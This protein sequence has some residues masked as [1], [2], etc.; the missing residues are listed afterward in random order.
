MIYTIQSIFYTINLYYN[1]DIMSRHIV[2]SALPY[3]NGKLHI[4]HVAGAYLPAD[5]YTRYLRLKE[6]DV[7]Y[8]C[9]T[10]EHGAP[11]SIKAEKEGVAPQVIVDRYHKSIKESF[12]GLNIE[13]DNF[14]GT[15]REPHHKLAQKFFTDLMENGFITSKVTQQFYDEKENRFL[16]DRYVEGVCPHC[17]ADGARGDQCDACGKLI[18]SITLQNPISKVS[19]TT[20][21]V[22]DTEQWYLDLPKFT[23]QL[24]EW[25]STK[26]YW[27]ENVVNF[28]MSW[29][30]EGLI[31]RAITRDINWGVKVPLTEALGK[32]LYVW[33]DAPIGYISSTIE[34]AKNQGKEELWKDY[35]CNQ[36][37]KL[38]HFIGKDNI[39]F[40]T[41][42]WPAFIMG[43]KDNYVLPHDVPANEYL[44]LEGQKI[45]TSRNWA[46][47]VDEFLQA[48]D[49][50]YLRYVLAV[51]APEK[52]DNDFLWKDFQNKINT[53]L[54]NVL[55][56]LGNRVFSFTKKHFAGEVTKPETLTKLSLETLE[57]T[58]KLITEID[59]NYSTYQVRKAVKNIM[60]IARLSNRY[61]DEREP[62]K[63]VKTDKDSVAETLY[64]C[65]EMLRKIS[66]VMSPIIPT[67]MGKLRS[68]MGLTNK[69]TWAEL[70]ESPFP[71]TLVDVKQI[72]FK[73]EDKQIAAQ[74]KLLQENAKQNKE[75]EAIEEVEVK[76][77][78]EFDD[79]MKMDLRIAEI[80]SAEKVKKTNKLLHVKVKIGTEERE[81]VAG[82][83]KAYKPEE[84]VGKKVVMLLNLKPRKIRG[85]LSS[86]MI[87]AASDGDK[88]SVLE[89][90]AAIRSG[91]TV[92]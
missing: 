27:K 42:M 51:N 9:G 32:V 47:W 17:S 44:N 35:W 11:I 86:G 91:S 12:D 49:G 76:P 28:I 72:F 89:P 6:E 75:E 3:A 61:F 33:F 52:Q 84:L 70:D 13:F 18:D 40:H 64:V 10:D 92:S 74:L 62:W 26:T 4:G 58:D 82:L 22:K 39:P 63:A 34:W 60:D 90:N 14:S 79:F 66:I 46:I 38:V 69:P 71:L 29:L 43:Q 54:N 50:E 5:I 1:G 87:L 36:D 2:T 20:P 88:L 77:E 8:I 67:F 80:I 53:E 55:G 57:A 45:S 85:V 21:V 25:L 65:C 81:L 19:G 31:E 56:N 15:A 24:K 41:I 73:V 78:I 7:I 48:F 37:T 16:P 83:A 30:N 68:I 59:K 23:E